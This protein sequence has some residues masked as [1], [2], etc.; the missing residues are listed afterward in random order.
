M[1]NKRE[2]MRREKISKDDYERCE[3]WTMKEEKE[4]GQFFKE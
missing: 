1:N 3:D 4:I 2:M